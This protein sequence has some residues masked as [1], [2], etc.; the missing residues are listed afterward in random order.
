MFRQ[1]RKTPQ[2]LIPCDKLTPRPNISITFVNIAIELDPL[3]LILPS[4][5]NRFRLRELRKKTQRTLFPSHS[6]LIKGTV[7]AI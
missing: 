7:V 2:N 1:L 3:R 5:K 6:K 4:E